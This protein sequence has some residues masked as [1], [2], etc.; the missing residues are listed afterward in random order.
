V[1]GCF[2]CTLVSLNLD[3]IAENA[4]QFFA[5]YDWFCVQEIFKKLVPN[6]VLSLIALFKCELNY[7]NYVWSYVK[8]YCMFRCACIYTF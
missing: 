8:I 7:L 5:L 6:I 2:F 1:I 4:L 3:L